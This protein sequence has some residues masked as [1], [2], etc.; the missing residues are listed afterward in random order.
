MSE[1]NAKKLRQ[2]YRREMRNEILRQMKF[3]RPKP[4]WIP[5]FIWYLLYK[6]IFKNK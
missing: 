5:I 1:K 6:I 3:L 2:L 4:K